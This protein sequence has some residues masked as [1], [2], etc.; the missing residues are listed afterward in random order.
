MYIFS[1]QKIFSPEKSY[2]SP[3]KDSTVRR[4]LI[5]QFTPTKNAVAALFDSPSKKLL[6]ETSK[7]ALTLPYKYRYLAEIFR[8]IDTVAQILFN[9]KET[10]TFRKLKPAVEE[11]LKRNLT[12][13]HLSQIKHIYPDAFDFAQEKLKVFGTGMKQERWELV[14]KPLI[15]D[16]EQFTSDILL[17]RRRTLFSKLL[18]LTKNY[19]HEFLSSLDPPLIISKNRITRWHP[20]F[21]IERVPDVETSE[22]PPPPEEQTFTSGKDV[23]EKAMKMFNCNARMEQALQ[24]LK[25]KKE[26]ETPDVKEESKPEVESVLKGK[27]NGRETVSH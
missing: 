22:L 13:T 15:G 7:P 6:E 4:N 11:M 3:K 18:D 12:E 21:D 2:L 27:F 14:L 24:K 9:R 19:H 16:E 20:E 5:H 26:K 23:L 1:P 17:Q 10:I 8:C 25:E